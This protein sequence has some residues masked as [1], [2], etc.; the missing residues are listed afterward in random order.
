[1]VHKGIRGRGG[2]GIRGG[3]E[4]TGTA[5]GLPTR[6]LQRGTI[7]ES[8]HLLIPMIPSLCNDRLQGRKL[9]VGH[10]QR[11]KKMLLQKGCAREGQEQCA[12]ERLASKRLA[13]RE[14]GLVHRVRLRVGVRGQLVGEDLLVLALRVDAVLHLVHARHDLVAHVQPELA[15]LAG[16]DERTVLALPV[17]RSGPDPV[18]LL[19][20]L[21]AELPPTLVLQRDGLCGRGLGR[22]WRDLDGGRGHLL[23]LLLGEREDVLEAGLA[24]ALTFAALPFCGLLPFM[25]LA[26]GLVLA[27][28]FARRGG[29]YGGVL[30]VGIHGL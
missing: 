17:P 10:R 2:F 13:L 25:S 11:P 19:D 23:Y 7:T 20:L 26:R 15:Q 12:R 29:G 24:V 30:P 28:P 6:N 22:W 16:L 14:G 27:R 8:T 5:V 9:F 3:D 4:R 1:M 18:P 21:R